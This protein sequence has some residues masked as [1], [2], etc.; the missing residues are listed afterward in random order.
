MIVSIIVIII[1]LL[2]LKNAFGEVHHNLIQE[3]LNYHHIPE[4]I[5]YLIQ[6][7][8]TDLKASIITYDFHTPFIT[9]GCGVLQGG[10]LS[11]LVFTLCFKTFI[12]HIK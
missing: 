10:C 4:H 11:S 5:K 1:T 2:Y 7:L 8:Y 6:S 9:V 12:Q 3:I